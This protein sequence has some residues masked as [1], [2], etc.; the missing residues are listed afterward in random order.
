MVFAVLS[1]AQ[2]GHIMAIKSESETIFGRNVLSNLPLLLTVFLTFLLQVA[3][4]YIP[5]FNDLLKTQPL[6]MNELLICVGVSVIVPIAVEIEKA[7]KKTKRT[8]R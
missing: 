8:R 6:S 1:F 5:F 7:V 3:V 4:I 2:L